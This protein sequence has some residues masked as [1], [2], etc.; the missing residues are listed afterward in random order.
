MVLLKFHVQKKIV[1]SIV[2]FAPYPNKSVTIK[3]NMNCASTVNRLLGQA[4][5]RT[6]NNSY[7]TLACSNLLYKSKTLCVVTL[8]LCGSKHRVQF[9]K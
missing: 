7:A 9:G 8:H 1:L 4:G 6:R 3:R 5:E 2:R